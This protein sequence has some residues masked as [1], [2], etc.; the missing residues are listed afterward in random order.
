MVKILKVTGKNE[1]ASKILPIFRLCDQI[2]FTIVEYLC[3]PYH[4]GGN[5]LSRG[6]TWLVNG[7]N[8]NFYIEIY[9]RAIFVFPSY[10]AHNPIYT[11]ARLPA[12]VFGYM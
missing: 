5:I 3:F 1:I 4:A 6:A 12:S 7:A 11:G 9:R 8:L 10:C 2:I